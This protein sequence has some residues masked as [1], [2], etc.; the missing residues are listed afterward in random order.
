[1]ASLVGPDPGAQGRL[2]RAQRAASLG[3]QQST[4][5]FKNCMKMLIPDD[6]PKGSMLKPKE[7]VSKAKALEHPFQA[8]PDLPLDL[9]F[10]SN[11]SIPDITSVRALRMQKAQRLSELA[12]KADAIDT[13]I[14]NRMP[15]DVKVSAGT[16]RLGFITV[17]TLL[18]R[19]PDWQMTSLYTRG[20]RV[21]GIVEPSNIY[22]SIDSTN[23]GTLHDLL[24]SD[25][26][27]AW[28]QKLSDDTKAYDHDKAVWDTAKDQLKRH[29]L[30]GPMTKQDL[31]KIFGKGRWRGIRR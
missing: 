12:D 24:Q 27:D 3:V 11:A 23:E 15:K 13:N 14:W 7:H 28:N 17:L 21:A 29:L 8:P 20:F 22:P 25:Q 2:N 30:S 18:L 5:L 6:N 16:A 26:A 4:H 9:Q 19:W 1:M 31:D 10:A